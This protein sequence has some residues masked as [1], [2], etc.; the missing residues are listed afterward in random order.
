[1]II[2]L[3]M[4]AFMRALRGRRDVH[5]HRHIHDNVTHHIHFHEHGAE[6][7]GTVASH[8]HSVSS[9]GFNQFLVGVMRGLAGAAALTLL[10]LTQIKSA[11]LY[12]GCPA[13]FGTGSILGLLLM[14]CLI[15]LP[16]ALSARRLSGAGL[17]TASDCRSVKHHFWIVVGL[18]GRRRERSLVSDSINDLAGL[19]SPRSLD[20]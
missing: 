14:P 13:V 3:D 15:G 10:V 19:S 9:I 7:A 17:R 2:G 11:A 1:M 20:K 18:P 16:F 4:T 12:L 5:I 8:R 6:H